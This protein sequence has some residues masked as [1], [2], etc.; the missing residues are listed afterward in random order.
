MKKYFY[1]QVAFKTSKI[2]IYVFFLG[3]STNSFAQAMIECRLLDSITKFPIQYA[4][5]YSVSSQTGTY[6][7]KDGWF[8]ILLENKS[9]SLYISMI[10]YQTLKMS[11]ENLDSTK[12]NI[13]HLNPISYHLNE[14]SVVAKKEDKPE[15][16]TLGYIN[17][18]K[19]ERISS[20]SRTEM[21]V[22]I[23]NPRY[24]NTIIKSVI[25]P[26]KKS[27]FLEKWVKNEDLDNSKDFQ[28]FNTAVRVHLYTVDS[29]DGKP[30]KELIP[31][32][33]V[34]VLKRLYKNDLEVNLSK[35]NIILPKEG[36]FVGIEWLGLVNDFTGE[37]ISDKKYRL[38][39]STSLTYKE[40][41][42]NTWFRNLNSGQI[43]F[44]EPHKAFQYLHKTD[45]VVNAAFGLK[46][47]LE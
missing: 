39:T 5:V 24:E 10:G 23:E 20:F 40:N 31:E 46:I 4:N 30:D 25:Y 22:F 34:I 44:Q 14:I 36:V 37:I 35:F 33:I 19:K 9:D 29:L 6:S 21:A 28:D 13:L 41:K 15:L 17:F 18:S 7:N 38:A 16:I 1:S 42:P 47:I 2:L 8:K 12:I 43:W 27:R 32:S 3:F 45:K 11:F 26:I